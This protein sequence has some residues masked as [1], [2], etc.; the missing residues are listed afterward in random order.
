MDRRIEGK[1]LRKTIYIHKAI[2]EAFVPNP[3]NLKRATVIDG[4]WTNLIPSNIRWIS[5]SELS[6]NMMKKNP[7]HQGR[8]AKWNKEN[9]RALNDWEIAKIKESRA[10]GISYRKLAELFEVSVGTIYKYSNQ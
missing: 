7:S 5:Q 6:T 1:L 2:A 9:R 3:Y 8:L 4:D 10:K